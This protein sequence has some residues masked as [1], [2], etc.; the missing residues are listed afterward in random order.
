MTFISPRSRQPNRWVLRLLLCVGV[1]RLTAAAWA[2]PLTQQMIGDVV[3]GDALTT[4]AADTNGDGETTAA[5]VA[6]PG[7]L[8]NGRVTGFFALNLNDALTYRVTDPMGGVT[9][10][11]VKVYS[12]NSAGGFE[13]NDIQVDSSQMLKNERQ[14]YSNANG[15]LTYDG[16]TDFLQQV[17]ST[18]TPKLLRLVL[19][20]IAGQMFSTTST[21]QVRTLQNLFV[22]VIQR[23]D[24]FMPIE[25]LE[26]LTVP[27]GTFRHIVH[28]SGSTDA[29]GFAQTE[30]AY[31]A[32]GIGAVLRLTTAG[33]DT[34]RSELV[35]GTINGHPIG[36]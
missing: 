21:C 16:D 14:E 17:R 23:T 26:S 27:A 35:G 13:L 6:I 36:Q 3:F 12:A 8:F 30:E 1:L 29:G 2:E 4:S 22:G 5:D 32:P 20:I 18:C 34:I 28:I 33:G 10:E 7:L 9:M 19:P 24:S 31:F 11:T 15:R 25:I